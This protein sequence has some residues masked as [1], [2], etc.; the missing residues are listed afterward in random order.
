MEALF[1]IGIF[2]KLAILAVA[3]TLLG[4]FYHRR[5]LFRK[6]LPPGPPLDP[7]IGQ[8]RTLPTAY[9]WV[10]FTEWRKKW[11]E[12]CKLALVLMTYFQYYP[13]RRDIHFCI[14]AAHRYTQ[15]Y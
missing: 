12:L 3:S 10:A 15:L 9:Q 11:G 5:R 6:G 8:V 7:V 4:I 14:R 13:R 1:S 2:D